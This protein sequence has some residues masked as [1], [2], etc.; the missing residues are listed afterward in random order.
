MSGKYNNN[1]K[2]SNDLVKT[3][4]TFKQSPDNSLNDSLR[5]S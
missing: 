5:Q 3:K 2:V 1:E 4:H